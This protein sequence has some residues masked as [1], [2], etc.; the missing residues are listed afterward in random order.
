MDT[1]IEQIVNIYNVN[2][3]LFINSFDG[4]NE[5]VALKRANKKTNSMI[6]IALHLIEARYFILN[7]LGVKIK[8]PFAKYV[9]RVKTINEIKKYPKLSKIL[10]DWKKLDKTGCVN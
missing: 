3:L 9:E 10:T 8:S 2:S 5:K 7:E 1:R 4:I 6:F